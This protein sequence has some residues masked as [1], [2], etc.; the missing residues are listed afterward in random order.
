M[1]GANGDE[2][3]NIEARNWLEKMMAKRETREKISFLSKLDES[4]FLFYAQIVDDL[5]RYSKDRGNTL[6][7]SYL[8][9][10]TAELSRTIDQLRGL[11]DQTEAEKGTLEEGMR[12]KEEALRNEQYKLHQAEM[13]HANEK[14][15]LVQGAL[16]EVNEKMTRVEANMNQPKTTAVLGQQGEDWVVEVLKQAFPPDTG[17]FKVIPTGQKVCGDIVLTFVRENKHIMFEV[18]NYKKGTTVMGVKQGK[19]VKKFFEDC[20]QTK[21]RYR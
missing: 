9:R 7:E 18:K 17:H 3:C 2:N 10:K 8:D 19:E 4:D 6:N 16:K 20:H 1:E 15:N 14:F 21:L 11:V 12:A 13:S 5:H